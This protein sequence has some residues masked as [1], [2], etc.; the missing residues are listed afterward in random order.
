VRDETRGAIVIFAGISLYAITFTQCR[1]L[2]ADIQGLTEGLFLAPV[3][4]VGS[5]G[6]VSLAEPEPTYLV[7]SGPSEARSRELM[8]GSQLSRWL[9]DPRRVSKADVVLFSQGPT[10][11]PKQAPSSELRLELTNE[12][13]RG[14]TCLSDVRFYTLE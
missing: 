13:P 6:V 4:A 9:C 3:R 11:R 1:A 7:L 8:T 10:R 14:L 5:V 2:S 12:A